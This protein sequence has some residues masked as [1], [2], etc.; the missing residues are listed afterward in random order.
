MF[1]TNMT[2]DIIYTLA[3][4]EY[5]CK[6]ILKHFESNEK[7]LL[8]SASTLYFPSRQRLDEI[9]KDI[10]E[11]LYDELIINIG[12]FYNFFKPN[13]NNVRIYKSV[14]GTVKPHIDI[15]TNPEETYTC[16]IYLSDDFYGG[17]LYI[18]QNTENISDMHI[19]PKKCH[20]VIFPK[21]CMHWNDELLEG[22][23][24]I[25]LLD[26]QIEYH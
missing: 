13:V 19:K 3:I 2:I 23:K 21:K 1:F 14:Y 4:S 16:L 8:F 22:N 11:K 12:C 26:C 6:E 17:N 20:G 15:P 18:R 5:L 10:K 25:L 7:I 24:I 9:P